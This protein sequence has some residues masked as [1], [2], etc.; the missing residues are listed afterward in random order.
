MHLLE[1]TGDGVTCNPLKSRL[2]S[3]GNE[4][5]EGIAIRRLTTER[6]LD[7]EAGLRRFVSSV[8]GKPCVDV[9]GAFVLACAPPTA[10]DEACVGRCLQVQTH[11]GQALLTRQGQEGQWPVRSTQRRVVPGWRQWRRQ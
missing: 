3:Y 9:C 4:Y 7:M 1:A 2:K 10:V 5:T 11:A 6:T 8:E